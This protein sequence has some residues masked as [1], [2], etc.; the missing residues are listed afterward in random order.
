MQRA[1]DL[2]PQG[3]GHGGHLAHVR[4]WYAKYDMCPTGC[5]HRQSCPVSCE[6]LRVRYA[7]AT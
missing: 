2:I 6:A 5:G 1:Y 4:E 7:V 3:C